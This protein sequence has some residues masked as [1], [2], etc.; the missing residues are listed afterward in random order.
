[1]EDLL[2]KRKKIRLENFSYSTRGAYFVTICTKDKA[3]I[4]SQ[5]VLNGN[6]PKVCLTAIGK[7][8]EEKLLSSEEIPGVKIDSYVIMPDHIHAIMLITEVNGTPVAQ[9]PTNEGLPHII[10][11]F[12]RLCHKELKS[13]IFQRSYIDHI[14]RDAKDYE[15]RKKYM[16]ENPIRWYYRR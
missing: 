8:V 4:L 3:P 5:V 10:S 14:I 9:S 13:V 15:T 7:V 6:M 16:Y 11:T 2:P 1:M 12:K